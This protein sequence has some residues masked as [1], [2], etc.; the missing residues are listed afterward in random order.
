M[1]I[2]S[3]IFFFAA[4]GFAFSLAVAGLA[5]W[6]PNLFGWFI[7]PFWILPGLVNLGAHDFAW[8]L[9]L[10]SGTIFYGVVVFLGYSLWQRVRRHDMTSARRKSFLLMT[11]V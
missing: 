11:M 8:P 1:R 7:L 6:A 10:L 5:S 9:M 3:R 4:L 2:L